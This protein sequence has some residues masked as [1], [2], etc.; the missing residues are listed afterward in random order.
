MTR[1]L[2]LL[3]AM[4]TVPPGRWGVAVSG[5]VDSVALLRLA[6]LQPDLQ[7][8]VIHLDHQTRGGASGDD[9]EFVGRVAQSLDVPLSLA[10]MSDVVVTSPTNNIPARYRAARYAFFAD[11]VRQFNL[12]GVLLAHHADDQAE[13]VAQR[14]LR[15]RQPAGLR[16][17][18]VDTVIDGVRVLRPLLRERREVLRRFLRSIDQSWVEDASN[19]SAIYQRNRVRQTIKDQPQLFGSL[20][21]LGDAATNLARWLDQ[22]TPVL[23]EAFDAGQLASIPQPLARHAAAR[24]LRDRGVPAEDVSPAVCDRLVSFAADFSGPARADFAG[25]LTVR[26]TRGRI[27]AKVDLHKSAATDRADPRK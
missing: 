26:R 27:S 8:H 14:L 17:M 4:S 22:S 2:H 21:N 23:P 7:P 25:G 9:A 12:T 20:L 15:G 5:G 3:Q 19:S 6:I 16:G 18:T 1:D 10:K 24:W 13:T 11:V